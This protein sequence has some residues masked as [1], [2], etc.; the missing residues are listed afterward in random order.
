MIFLFL[1]LIFTDCIC[2]SRSIGDVSL[3][4]QMF[5]VY[6]AQLKEEAKENER[7]RKEERV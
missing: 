1:I 7:K 4:K 2:F 3:S 6:V 5:E